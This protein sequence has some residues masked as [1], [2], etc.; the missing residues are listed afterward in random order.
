MGKESLVLGTGLCL[1][2]TSLLPGA[3]CP[4]HSS[5]L[6]ATQQVLQTLKYHLPVSVQN[7]VLVTSWFHL[8]CKLNLCLLLLSSKEVPNKVRLMERENVEW[9]GGEWC[10][11]VD[12]LAVS[13]VQPPPQ[14]TAIRQSR[15]DKCAHC[16][17]E[18]EPNL[19]SWAELQ[20]KCIICI[21]YKGAWSKKQEVNNGNAH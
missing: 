15:T 7:L 10:V 18:T 13:T 19:S 9:R 2:F 4:P 3:S 21:L 17:N 6:P 11:H 5:H 1:M 14:G 12:K 20:K 16:L 8:I